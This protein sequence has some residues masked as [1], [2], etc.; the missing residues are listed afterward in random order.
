MIALLDRGQG[1]Y[2]C[3]EVRYVDGRDPDPQGSVYRLPQVGVWALEELIP[4]LDFIGLIRSSD[5]LIPLDFE[6]SEVL[7]AA[8]PTE[9]GPRNFLHADL[10][11]TTVSPTTL[12][13]MYPMALL[14][15]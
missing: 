5:I 15:M 12:G 13:T 11:N 7:L 2:L 4:E 14:I 8:S 1:F 6:L 3:E 10:F 9:L